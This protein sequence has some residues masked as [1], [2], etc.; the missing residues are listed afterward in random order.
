MNGIPVWGESLT[1]SL[2]ENGSIGGVKWETIDDKAYQE[3]YFPEPTGTLSLEE[4]KHKLKEYVRLVYFEA[5]A[6]TK[7]SPFSQSVLEKRQS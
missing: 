1:L 6:T 5:Y 7:R 2:L 3:S 4:L